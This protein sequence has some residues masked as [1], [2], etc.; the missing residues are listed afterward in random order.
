MRLKC[1][2]ASIA[3]NRYPTR[4]TYNGS[5]NKKSYFINV[6]DIVVIDEMKAVGGTVVCRI[7]DCITNGK[8][9]GVLNKRWFA[10]DSDYFK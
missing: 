9:S 4:S 3:P 1:V 10:Y 2:K 5:Y 6:G 8:S 7:A